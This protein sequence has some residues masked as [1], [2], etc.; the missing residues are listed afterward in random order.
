MDDFNICELHVIQAVLKKE[1]VIDNGKVV[2]SL[3]YEKVQEYG[4]EID[5]AEK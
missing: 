4:H 5:Q 3:E 1:E 2:N